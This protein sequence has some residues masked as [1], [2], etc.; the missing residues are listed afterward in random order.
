MTI[1][2]NP[3][4]DAPL[5]AA[6]YATEGAVSVPGF[7][8]PASA[9][10][11]AAELAQAELWVEIFRA[12]EKVYEMPHAQFLALPAAQKDELR[13]KIEDAARG[14][15]QYRY[16]AIR[17]SEDAAERMTRGLA[18]DR[19]ADALNAPATI[20]LLRTITGSASLDF[21]DAQAT[22]YRAGDF[23]TTHDDAIEGKNRVAAYVYSLTS[24]W[25]ADWGGL[26]LF[27]RGAEV[28][29]FVPD[30]NVLRLFAVPSTHHVSYVA[31]WVDARR[32]S[33]TGWLR[34]RVS[35]QSGA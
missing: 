13:R 33:V 31:P 30:Y 6:R 28:T 16:R 35:G 19:F 4:P 5:L 14:G 21:A 18:L 2:L 10:E 17:V 12:G 26:L 15:L 23:L 29:G 32:L 20:D 7:L 25:Q 34:S 3:R 24:H 1:E 11:L 9:E 8:S 27:E 22:D